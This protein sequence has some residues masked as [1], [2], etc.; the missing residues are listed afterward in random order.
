MKIWAIYE[1]FHIKERRGLC[2]IK[3]PMT[4]EMAK[5]MN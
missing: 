2:L 3:R 4:D 5:N 1:R